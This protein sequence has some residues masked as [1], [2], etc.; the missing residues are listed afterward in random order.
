[1]RFGSGRS[2]H[3]LLTFYSCESRVHFIPCVFSRVF[4]GWCSLSARRAD[5]KHKRSRHIMC[6]DRSRESN[7]WRPGWS[8]V[9]GPWHCLFPLLVRPRFRPVPRHTIL[10]TNAACQSNIHES[11]AL[12]VRLGHL[13]KSSD[14]SNTQSLEPGHGVRSRIRQVARAMPVSL[15]Q[16]VI[17]PGKR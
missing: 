3:A 5:E 4:H 10:S 12:D 15:E 1:M 11:T 16:Q 13:P 9:R 17:R 7:S 14:L 8:G 6:E 2:F